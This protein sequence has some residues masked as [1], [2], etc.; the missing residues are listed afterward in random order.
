MKT[1]IIL[2]ALLCAGCNTRAANDELGNAGVIKARVDPVTG[3]QYI[4]YAEG[5]ITPRMGADGKQ[6]CHEVA[7]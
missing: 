6:I 2:L 4:T 3:C 1:S 7:K 5:G